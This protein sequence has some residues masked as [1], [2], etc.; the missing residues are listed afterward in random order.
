MIQEKLEEDFSCQIFECQCSQFIPNGNDC[1]SYSTALLHIITK[2]I[3]L[4]SEFM[5]IIGEYS[6]SSQLP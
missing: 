2:I 5:L 1:S 3:H 4:V 6:C